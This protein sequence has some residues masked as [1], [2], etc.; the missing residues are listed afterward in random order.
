MEASAGS[1]SCRMRR[2]MRA[3]CRDQGGFRKTL[4]GNA[5]ADSN[6]WVMEMQTVGVTSELSRQ[7]RAGGDR[8]TC[9]VASRCSSKSSRSLTFLGSYCRHVTVLMNVRP[10][11][12]P[13]S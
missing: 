7:L 11:E 3:R 10:I 2:N 1:T 9:V 5:G 4:S 8:F 12:Q 6:S 13:S